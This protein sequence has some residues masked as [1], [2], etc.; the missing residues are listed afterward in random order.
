VLL[1]CLGAPV[2]AADPSAGTWEGRVEIAGASYDLL[3]DLRAASGV[4]ARGP[5]LDLR[6][7]DLEQ[8]EDAIRFRIEGLPGTVSFRGTLSSDGTLLDGSAEIVPD[9]IPSTDIYLVT[10]D[11]AWHVVSARNVTDRD[12]YD[13]QPAFEPGGESFL[14]TSQRDGQTDIYRHV[15]GAAAPVRVTDTA[16]TSEYSPT[17]MPGGTGFSVVRVE[18]D[19]TQRLWAFDRDGGGPRLLL[20]DAR[21]VGYHAWLGPSTVALFV[22]GEPPTLQ[23]ADLGNGEAREVATSIGRG[24]QPAPGGERTV[25]YVHKDDET[26]WTLR[27][28]GPQAPAAILGPTLPGGEDFAY[29]PD[30]SILMGHGSTLQTFGSDGTW[31]VRIDLSPYGVREIT[32]VAVHPGGRSLAVVGA[33]DS[34]PPQPVTVPVTFRRLA[35]PEPQTPRR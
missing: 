8:S 11:R 30:G 13:N 19:G 15:P 2:R 22:L 35:S 33:R 1:L 9:A 7:A 29:L 24:M 17:P 27:Q 21:P 26:V 10:L 3:L 31:K 34:A 32:R 14:Y 28:A 25:T 16:D 18:E 4:T 20:P 5:E 12:G 23:I 6:L